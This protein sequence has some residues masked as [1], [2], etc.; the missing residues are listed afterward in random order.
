M[1]RLIGRVQIN[2][3]CSGESVEFRLICRV[4]VNQSYSGESVVFM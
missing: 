4:R 2:Q 3:S 1:F